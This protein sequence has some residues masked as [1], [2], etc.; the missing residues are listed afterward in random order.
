MPAL[1]APLMQPPTFRSSATRVILAPSLMFPSNEVVFGHVH[2]P[3]FVNGPDRKHGHR[4]G[5]GAGRGALRALGPP[6]DLELQG[7]GIVSTDRVKARAGSSLR[8]QSAGTGPAV[9]GFSRRILDH[10]DI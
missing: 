10:V 5:R 9:K 3:G 1:S 2:G 4:I 6:A 7:A 8:G